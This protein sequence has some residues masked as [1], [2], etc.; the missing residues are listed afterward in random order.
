MPRARTERPAILV[1]NPGSTSTR[2]ALFAPERG[3][4]RFLAEHTVAHTARA[5][6]RFRRVAEQLPM[7]ARLVERWL[8][9]R[10]ARLAAVAGRGGLLAPLPGGTYRVNAAMLRD[11]ALARRGE[12]AS[13]LGALIANRIARP[14]RIPAFVVDPVA[15]DE[16]A[17]EA[18]LTG[19]PEIPRRSV[20]HAL[21][22]KAAARRA[23]AAL[24]KSYAR[25][26]L[27]IAH[28]GGGISVGAHRGGRVVEVNN[29]LDGEGPF[30]PE[31]AGTLPAG[32]LVRLATSSKVARAAL[33][34]R[35]A[36]RG[37]LVAHLGTNS[38]LEAERRARRSKRARLVLDAMA[39]GVARAICAAA[40]ALD[41]RVDAVAITGAMAGSR[42]LVNSIRRRV[43]FL[44]PVFMYPENL[45]MVALAEGALRVLA[46]REHSRVYRPRGPRKKT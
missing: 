1:V 9:G 28:L 34:R 5:L 3:S 21:S 37:G 44:G 14:R 30:S 23:A 42:R 26:R 25:A 32:D 10:D 36:G 16:L 6:A 18:R 7:R 27:I 39:Y 33:L 24:G 31:R 12:H 4:V 35:I 8:A 22:Q 29:A 46:G 11:L 17:P 43:A 41:G 13:N 40:A 2:V 15:V 38:L 45:E 20:F 19:L